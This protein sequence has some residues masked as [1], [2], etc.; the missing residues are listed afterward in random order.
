MPKIAFSQLLRPLPLDF[1]PAGTF[2]TPLF[3]QQITAPG[4]WTYPSPLLIA[5]IHRGMAR[6]SWPGCRVGVTGTRQ[7]L[8]VVFVKL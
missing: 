7:H 2:Y 4:V 6:L 8:L 5:L 1:T 3:P